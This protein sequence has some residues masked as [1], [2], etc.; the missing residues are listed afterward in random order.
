MRPRSPTS[1][2]GPAGMG[3]AAIRKMM[4]VAGHK[5]LAS[6]ANKI[7]QAA[8][9]P[10]LQGLEQRAAPV[11]GGMAASQTANPEYQNSLAEYLKRVFGQ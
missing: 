6:G 10:A 7:V 5:V 4:D 8:K 11:V 9:S 1:R 2:G 3:M